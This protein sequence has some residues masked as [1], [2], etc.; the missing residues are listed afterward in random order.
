MEI[1][2]TDFVKHQAQLVA[3]ELI[4]LNCRKNAE[5]KEEEA[6]NV[7][8]EVKSEIISDCKGYSFVRLSILSEENSFDINIQEKGLFEFSEVLDN[9][10]MERFLI[11]QGVRL[12]WSYLRECVYD[13]TGKMLRKPYL[14]PT[15]DVFKTLSNIKDEM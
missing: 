6:I 7:S 4:E 8:L 2:I 14:L 11:L 13:I 10:N 15:I 9:E 5:L 12:L 1:N 3:V